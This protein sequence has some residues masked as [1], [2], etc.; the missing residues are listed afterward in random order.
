MLWVWSTALNLV[1]AR[2]GVKRAEDVR[3]GLVAL[4]SNSELKRNYATAANLRTM[5]SIYMERNTHSVCVCDSFDMFG[6]SDISDIISGKLCCEYA[7][8]YLVYPLQCVSN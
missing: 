8:F 3:G 2:T 6:S 1:P 7:I 4:F 5:F